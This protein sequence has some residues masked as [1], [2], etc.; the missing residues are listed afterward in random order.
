MPMPRRTRAKP[1]RPNPKV[2]N[3][4]DKREMSGSVPET[5]RSKAG[6]GVG[7]PPRIEFLAQAMPSFVSLKVIKVLLN[8]SHQRIASLRGEGAL[9]AVSRMRASLAKTVTGPP[10]LVSPKIHH[11]RVMLKL[12]LFFTFQRMGEFTHKLSNET[13]PETGIKAVGVLV[14]VGSGV[15]IGA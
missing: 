13:P 8:G 14:D 5:G 6:V 4:L 3:I 10:E 11:T 12:L 15:F 2:D 7:V 1:K 9:S